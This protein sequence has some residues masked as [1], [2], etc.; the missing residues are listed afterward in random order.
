MEKSSVDVLFV[1]LLL[2]DVID[3]LATMKARNVEE[4]L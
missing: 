4:N 2:D 3:D 1:Y